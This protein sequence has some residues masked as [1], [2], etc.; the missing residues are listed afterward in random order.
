MTLRL[1]PIRDDE[2]PLLADILSEL[3][4]DTPLPL[5]SVRATWDAIRR[6][7]DYDCYFAESQGEVIGCLSMLVFPVFAHALSSEAVVEA[8]VVRPDYR[9]KA[10]GRAM[11]RAAMQIASDKG[12]YKL[13]LSSNQRRLDAH[14][15]YDGMGFTRHGVSFSIDTVL[16]R[17]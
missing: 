17:A 8:V 7:P 12:A 5:D 10:L 13:A 9:G 4:G 3:D 14:R 16:P 2:L 15:F 1:R 6:Y 11:L